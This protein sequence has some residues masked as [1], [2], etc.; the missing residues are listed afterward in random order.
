MKTKIKKIKNEKE[1]IDEERKKERKKEREN[2][3]R[4]N[5]SINEQNTNKNKWNE[6][7]GHLLSH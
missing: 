5:E 6:C 2:E 7:G 3:L 4:K 1:V